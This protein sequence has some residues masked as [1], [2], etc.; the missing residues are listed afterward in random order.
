[1]NNL[2]TK[3][4]RIVYGDGVLGVHHR[5]V[6]YLFSYERGGLE[7]LRF[8][9]QEWLYRGPKPA[10]WRATTDNDRG[11]GFSRRSAQ[12]LG[13][14]QFSTVTNFVVS[15]DQQTIGQPIAPQNNHYDDQQFATTVTIVF[16]YTTATEPQTAVDVSYTVMPAGTL[17]VTAH[18][19]GRQGLPELPVFGLRFVTPTPL[20][21]YT[22]RGLSGE[23]YPD[24]WHGGEVGTYDI[25]GMPI[26]PYLVPQEMGMHIKTDSVVLKNLAQQGLR[27]EKLAQPFAFSVLPFSPLELEAATHLNE[28][29]PVRRGVVSIL[30]AVRGVGGID[31]W[32]ADVQPAYR[33]SGE[34]NHQVQFLITP[35]AAERID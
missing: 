35:L 20:Q 30:G 11:N 24:R 12:W 18:Y 15:V 21:G 5:A 6:S 32:G 27:I 13:A 3:P 25:A 17:Q 7:S 29:P 19:T 26:S 33:V 2:T 10:F 4:L 9:G 31:S 22:Y 8:G 23:T 14:D 34:Q 16:T 28:L 1:M